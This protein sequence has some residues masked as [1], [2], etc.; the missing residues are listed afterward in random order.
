MLKIWSENKEQDRTKHAGMLTVISYTME[1]C[2]CLK[3]WC[4]VMFC[5]CGND[6]AC[7]GGFK[8]W[9]MALFSSTQRSIGSDSQGRVTAA[10]NQR[11]L[12]S[13]PKKP[14]NFLPLHVNTNKSRDSSASA[15]P[16]TPTGGKEAKELFAPVPVLPVKEPSGGPLVEGRREPPIDSSQVSVAGVITLWHHA[17]FPAYCGCGGKKIR[18]ANIDLSFL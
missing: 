3:M 10:N 2:F 18:L 14:F 11:Q 5:G 8:C 15:P 12:S 7:F 16:A 13:E 1:S 6:L 4:R 17:G 9:N